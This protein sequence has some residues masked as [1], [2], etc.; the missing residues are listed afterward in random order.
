M[1]QYYQVLSQ[2]D[3][4][5]MENLRQFYPNIVENQGVQY[6]ISHEAQP[7]FQDEEVSLSFSLSTSY[8]FL[9]QIL[10]ASEKYIVVEN[11]QQR[12]LVDPGHFKNQQF[13]IQEPLNEVTQTTYFMEEPKQVVDAVVTKS[14]QQSIVV[15]PDAGLHSSIP[16][17][18]SKIVSTVRKPQIPAKGIQN[19]NVVSNFFIF[20]VN[21]RNL[22]CL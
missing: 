3:K 6:V 13:V 11:N 2:G 22:L 9:F 17:N 18:M 19:P 20:Y 15:T 5:N 12:I 1:A 8:C 4:V 16:N 14:H 10:V 21:S 7:P